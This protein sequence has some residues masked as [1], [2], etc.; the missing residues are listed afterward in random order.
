[1]QTYT[2]ICGCS[3]RP[4]DPSS[5]NKAH[6]MGLVQNSAIHFISNIKGRADSVSEAKTRLQLLFLED[7]HLP[8][9]LTRILQKVS[10]AHYPEPETRLLETDIWW[11]SPLVQL[12]EESLSPYP[13]IKPPPTQVSCQELSLR[14]VEKITNNYNA[15]KCCNNC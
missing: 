9:F 5:R 15:T 13:S 7:S 10:T 14:C 4:R 12:P 8:Y 2:R 6:D 1:M 3:A 11:Q